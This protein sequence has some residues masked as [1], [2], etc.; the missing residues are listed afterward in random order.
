LVSGHASISPNAGTSTDASSLIPSIASS[1]NLTNVSTT[2]A[3]VSAPGT[4]LPTLSLKQACIVGDDASQKE[5]NPIVTETGITAGTFCLQIDRNSANI[6]AEFSTYGNWRIQTQYLWI[7]SDVES[8]PQ[9]M[10]GA[11]DFI[12]FPYYGNDVAGSKFVTSFLALRCNAMTAAYSEV[13]IA[14][15]GMLQVDFAGSFV[16]NSET[17][18]FAQEY[19]A[20][21]SDNDTFGWFDFNIRCD[22][23]EK[24]VSNT[25]VPRTVPPSSGTNLPTAS[26]VYKPLPTRPQPTNSPHDSSSICFRDTA[27]DIMQCV[28][29]FASSGEKLGRACFEFLSDPVRVSI[30][31]TSFPGWVFLEH[32]MWVGNDVTTVPVGQGGTPDHLK[33]AY[34]WQNATGE[35]EWRAYIGPRCH[36]TVSGFYLQHVMSRITMSRQ[37]SD[38][39]LFGR[40]IIAEFGESYKHFSGES[41]W[42][43]YLKYSVD[44]HCTTQSFSSEPSL[45]PL[46]PTMCLRAPVRV[47]R[48]CHHLVSLSNQVLG[49]VCISLQN[50]DQSHFLL[51]FAADPG[52]TFLHHDA[53]VGPSVNF[54]PNRGD[55]LDYD[56]F[57][58]YWCDSGGQA[59]W[60]VAA[61]AR[62]HDASDTK[63]SVVVIVR[64]EAA[65]TL[66]NSDTPIPNT[67]TTGFSWG[68]ADRGLAGRSWFQVDIDCNCSFVGPTLP[69]YAPSAEPISEANCSLTMSAEGEKIQEKTCWELT[70]QRGAQVGEICLDLHGN[71]IDVSL[72]AT[73]YWSFISH[74]LWTGRYAS[75]M[76]RSHNGDINLSNFPYYYCNSTGEQ[77][78]MIQM[79]T[80]CS[81]HNPEDMLLSIIS[82]S[83]AAQ[84][85]PSTGDVI[86]GS[87]EIVFIEAHGTS[88]NQSS[89]GWLD[90]EVECFCNSTAINTTT[91]TQQTT[92][93]TQAPSSPVGTSPPHI[94]D[95]AC[96]ETGTN[97]SEECHPI[98]S[99]QDKSKVGT[100]CAEIIDQSTTLQ[101]L[102]LTFTTT[103]GW[104]FTRNNMWIDSDIRSLPKRVDGGPDVHKFPYFSKKTNTGIDT[105]EALVTLKCHQ[106]PSSTYTLTAVAQ[107]IVIL[108][109]GN[110]SSNAS[111][112]LAYAAEREGSRGVEFSWMDFQINCNCKRTLTNLPTLVP[113]TVGSQ[114]QCPGGD[115]H[116]QGLCRTL[117]TERGEK[118]GYICV[119]QGEDSDSADIIF[120]ADKHWALTSQEMWIGYDLASVPTAEDGTPAFETFPY[121][122]Q[123]IIGTNEWSANVAVR[124]E[125]EG[126][127]K[128]YVVSRSTLSQANGD[129]M[130]FE[131]TKE[132]AFPMSHSD[133]TKRDWLHFNI[134]CDS[135]KAKLVDPIARANSF[136]DAPNFSMDFRDSSQCGTRTIPFAGEC[137]TKSSGDL[138]LVIVGNDSNA[139]HL[140]VSFKTSPG[141][142]FTR[143]ELWLGPDL[144]H[145][146]KA[147]DGTPNLDLFP[148]FSFEDKEAYIFK[149][150]LKLDCSR[151]SE[152]FFVGVAHATTIQYDLESDSEVEVSQYAYEYDG[153]SN[154]SWYGYF[155]FSILC[156]CSDYKKL[157]EA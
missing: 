36:R 114:S 89:V 46:G 141:Q 74:H 78:W 127:H 53:W 69:S 120:K 153:V 121:L 95:K 25:L 107:S 145:L 28:F 83:R 65:Q 139:H 144:I 142:T 88:G 50:D 112:V 45:P 31:F 126:S 81:K 15:L 33:F 130:L 8:A 87:E 62:C 149:A 26:P 133:V 75:E 67:N 18:A 106:Y 119:D 80:G 73:S 68:P 155:D 24:Q 43:G 12:V 79:Q 110:P 122:W 38:G 124:C 6:K 85:D 56:S 66:P 5:C 49:N 116:P 39:T 37:N 156:I 136:C 55:I 105:W 1:T 154:S 63:Q 131:N 137:D 77:H 35:S 90:L 11:L 129:G 97:N 9:K 96:L 115:Y 151:E 34:L 71:D 10:N 138:S 92:H 17:V 143:T 23:S 27:G 60:S 13:G 48:S 99:S 123:D 86:V 91:P 100:I 132:V 70:T 108:T 64:S 94:Q 113:T 3:P 20:Q 41:S 109:A 135:G 47:E 102:R 93:S 150:P 19:T 14:L 21:S 32:R 146:P 61:E 148:H 128:I 104:A 103:A 29:I 118:A 4:G 58:I 57:P 40:T 84:V 140:E 59:V 82:L 52:W 117:I 16:P 157:P 125:E 44:C 7:G 101:L 22:C 98:L 2:E 134:N 30:L 76:P 152:L 147:K 72:E 51:E 54:A 111:E 42:Y